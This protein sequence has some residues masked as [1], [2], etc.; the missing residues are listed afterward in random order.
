MAH[1]LGLVTGSRKPATRLGTKT[2]GL[3][4]VAAS[5]A[6]ACRVEL[7]HQDGADQVLVRLTP[8]HG[9]GIARVLYDGPI[10][11]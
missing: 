5:W 3:V 4:T 11:S 6:G 7:S 10:N 2:S 1:Y 9:A 8:W